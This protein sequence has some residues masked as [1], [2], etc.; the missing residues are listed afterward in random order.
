M[1][2]FLSL[3]I[4]SCATN[5]VIVYTKYSFIQF[6]RTNYVTGWRRPI[7]CLE[8][9]VIVC[10]RADNYMALLRKMTYEDKASYEFTPLFILYLHINILFSLMIVSYATKQVICIHIHEY[11]SPETGTVS[12]IIRKN[13]FFQRTTSFKEQLLSKNNFFQRTTSFKEQILSSCTHENLSLLPTP[14]LSFTRPA[15]TSKSTTY[16]HPHAHTCK[17]GPGAKNGSE[18]REQSLGRI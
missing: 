4:L 18:L 2:I 5:Q 14:T 13:N 1:N 11:L 8:L 7:G 6:K 3:M 15:S 17:P 10:K 16:I 12:C 9:Q